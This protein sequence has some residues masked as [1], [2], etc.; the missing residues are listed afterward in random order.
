[1]MAAW[2]KLNLGQQWPY[3]LHQKL[4]RTQISC[5]LIGGVRNRARG[6]IGL[7]IETFAAGPTQIALNVNVLTLRPPHPVLTISSPW[8]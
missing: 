8:Q 3:W 7:I 5:R 6:G 2:R 1:M 4:G